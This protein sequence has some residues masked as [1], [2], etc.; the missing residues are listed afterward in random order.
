MKDRLCKACGRRYPA[1]MVEC[2]ACRMPAWMPRPPPLPAPMSTAEPE[3][4]WGRY[5]ALHIGPVACVRCR[6]VGA[7]GHQRERRPSGAGTV[8]VL[9]IVGVLFAPLLGLALLMAAILLDLFGGKTLWHASCQ[10]CGSTEVVP[11]CTPEGRRIVEAA[12]V[13]PRP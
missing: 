13:T 10:A 12:D 7:R 2:P 3:G 5:K 8:F 1:M 4:W 9:G 11:V 6:H